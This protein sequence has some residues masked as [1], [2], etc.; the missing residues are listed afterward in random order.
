MPDCLK[1]TVVIVTQRCGKRN[2]SSFDNFLAQQF[3][4]KVRHQIR[5]DLHRTI[6]T[7]RRLACLASAADE[8][9]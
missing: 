3:L 7:H 4:R 8:V 6:R 2:P 1:Q 9:T 5:A